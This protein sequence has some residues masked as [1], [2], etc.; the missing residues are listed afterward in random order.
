MR[1]PIHAAND[2]MAITPHNAGNVMPDPVAH[3][4]SK[5]YFPPCDCTDLCAIADANGG[6]LVG[7]QFEIAAIPNKGKGDT[8]WMENIATC[9]DVEIAVTYEDVLGAPIEAMPG[10]AA[11]V[12]T[13]DYCTVDTSQIMT[14]DQ[15]GAIGYIGRGDIGLIVVTIVAD[16]NNDLLKKCCGGSGACEAPLFQW[17]VSYDPALVAR[18]AFNICAD[19]QYGRDIGCVDCPPDALVVLWDA[20]QRKI[21][22]GL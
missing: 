13:D 8:F 19:A 14:F 18:N 9:P 22:L 16:P 10:Q 12:F 1:V 5:N 4:R 17:G 11:V 15:A 3:F 2:G 20:S 6:T 7:V 21:D